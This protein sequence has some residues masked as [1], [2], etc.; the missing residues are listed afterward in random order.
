MAWWLA[1]ARVTTLLCNDNDGIDVRWQWQCEERNLGFGD[2][3]KVRV[4]KG[5]KMNACMGRKRKRDFGYSMAILQGPKKIQIISL[6]V[7]IV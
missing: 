2:R 7:S 5:K 6:K 1:I 3:E 4:W